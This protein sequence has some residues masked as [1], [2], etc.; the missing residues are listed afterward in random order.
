[1]FIASCSG[2]AG[3]NVD[4]LRRVFRDGIMHRYRSLRR[5]CSI[6]VHNPGRRTTDFPDG[7]TTY[8]TMLTVASGPSLQGSY[9]IH[10]MSGIADG[11]H[12]LDADVVMRITFE[13]L[14]GREVAKVFGKAQRRNDADDEALSRSEFDAVE[15]A[16]KDAQLRNLHPFV[17]GENVWAKVHMS[18]VFGAANYHTLE[19]NVQKLIDEMAA[20]DDDKDDSFQL[21]RYGTVTLRCS[22]P[23]FARSRP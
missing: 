23:I 17:S 1:M 13:E 9:A 21:Y 20:T 16:D 18:F 14:S 10:K 2:Q 8:Q 7:Y 6:A 12:G 5:E 4:R 22:R 15:Y 19:R 11:F 3:G